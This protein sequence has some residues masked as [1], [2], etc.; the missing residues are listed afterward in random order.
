MKIGIKNIKKKLMI[1]VVEEQ[2]NIKF[3]GKKLNESI[4]FHLQ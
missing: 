1:I 2:M 3:I 4:I